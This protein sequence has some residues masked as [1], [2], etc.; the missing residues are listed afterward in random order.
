MHDLF[1][2]LNTCYT[3]IKNYPYLFS[4]QNQTLIHADTFFFISSVG[5]VVVTFLVTIGLIY[6]I[7]I[8]H[9]VR[10]ITEKV[11]RGINTVEEDTK[12]LVSDLRESMIFRMLF[13]GRKSK[14]TPI[15]KTK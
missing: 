4:M 9:S 13:G 11:E 1:I 15:K 12:E 6:I 2:S 3:E 8:L 5:F 10:R 14:K 7:R